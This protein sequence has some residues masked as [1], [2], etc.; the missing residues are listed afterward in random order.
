MSQLKFFKILAVLF[1]GACYYFG[2]SLAGNMGWLI[3]IAPAPI[4]FIALKLKPGQVFLLAFIAYLIGRLSWVSYLTSVMPPVPAI[5]ATLILP[6]VFALLAIGHRKVVLISNHWISVF[7]FPILFTA[8]EYLVFIFSKDGTAASIAYTQSN[9]LALIQIAS[10]TGMLGITFL[11]NFIPCALALAWYFREKVHVSY[12]LLGLFAILLA[13]TLI[14]GWIRLNK[15]DTGRT[16][17]IGMV[18]INEEAYHGVFRHD[19]GKELELTTLYLQESEKLAG[20]G[21][22]IIVLPEK[23][24]YVRDSN[25]DSILQK[26]T[27]FAASHHVQMIVGVTKQKTDYYTNNAWVISDQGKLLADYQKVNLFEGESLEGCRPGK[28]IAVFLADTVKQGVAICKDMDF[29]HFILGYSKQAPAILFVPA[30]DFVK[31]GWLHDRM[32]IMRSVE[33][34]FSM[35][36]NARQG[37]LTLSDW[38]GRV[39]YEAISEPGKRISLMGK[40]TVE[41]HPTTYARAGDW[42]GTINMFAALGLIAYMFTDRTRKRNRALYSKKK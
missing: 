34:G 12:I 25:T 18:S 31:D 13:D 19:L 29:Q 8:F 36:R 5:G 11:V 35:A 40:L 2:F 9:Y 22:E 17:Q 15:A 26:F 4:L 38:K 20:G 39:L 33:G 10:K 21:A 27:T 14:F 7:A 32:A 6:L 30:W 24:I 23:A 1:T 42:F 16:L 41:P 37:R 28:D 3:W